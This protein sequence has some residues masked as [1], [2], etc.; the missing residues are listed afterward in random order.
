M[1]VRLRRERRDPIRV[2]IRR[3]PL[4]F[5]LY[6]LWERAWVV[7]FEMEDSGTRSHM[8]T[9]VS[10]IYREENAPLSSASEASLTSCSSSSSSLGTAAAATFRDLPVVAD[11]VDAGAFFVVDDLERGADRVEPRLGF[12]GSDSS[13]ASSSSPGSSSSSAFSSGT[14]VAAALARLEE[15]V[16]DFALAVDVRRDAAE[17]EEAGG[18]ILSSSSSEAGSSFTVVPRAA[19]DERA[20]F[21]ADALAARRDGGMFVLLKLRRT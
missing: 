6:A 14:A 2:L 18:A 11:F 7:L 13:S 12:T 1:L 3:L 21:V 20:G 4:V 16:A 17:E 9:R 15:E 8:R 5:G 10:S 19:R